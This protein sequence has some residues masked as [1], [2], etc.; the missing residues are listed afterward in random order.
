M[1]HLL[2]GTNEYR[3]A[4][5]LATIA[6]EVGV[7]RETIDPAELD[8]NGLA[9]I[10]RGVSLFAERRLIVMRQL[11]EQKE[12][13]HK[14]GE[15]APEVSPETTLVLIEAKPD[16]RT[17]PYKTL[18]K[19]A[20]ITAVEPLTDRQRPVAERW[21][22][23]YA[24]QHGVSLTK[25]QVSDMVA[26]AVVSDDA[27]YTATIDQSLLAHAVEAL[28]LCETVTDEAIATVLPPAREFSVFDIMALAIRRQTAEVQAALRELRA[29]DDPYRVAPLLWSQWY[30]LAAVAVGEQV[31]DAQLAKEIGLHPFVIKK[32]RPLVRNISWSAI[33]E[34]TRYAVKLDVEMKSTS[35][36]PW[37]VIER[38]LLRIS[39]RGE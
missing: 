37:L 35:G 32:T 4:E 11:S 30:Q 9:D 18:Q 33:R 12:L 38:F 14:M 1:I 2:V 6:A 31:S 21:L 22:Q 5:I 16:K 28:A 20:T 23:Q 19:N 34:L 29:N 17:K 25:Q 10:V 8:R 39:Q 15:W 13:W 36:D 7:T 24:A 3:I 27:G 26:R